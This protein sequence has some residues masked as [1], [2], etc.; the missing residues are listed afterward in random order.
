MG[1][2]VGRGGLAAS[3]LDAPSFR[4][5]DDPTPTPTMRHHAVI[6]T[7]GS[8][9]GNPGPGGWAATI[10]VL[11]D[12]GSLGEAVVL[13]GGV[14]AT[15]NNRMEVVAAIEALR[16]FPEGTA[17]VFSDSQYLIKGSPNGFGPGSPEGGRTRKGGGCGT[18]TYGRSSKLS[19][20]DGISS[21]PGSR[22][23]RVTAVTRRSTA[24]PMQRP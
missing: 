8:C 3:S 17:T 6:H 23:T 5:V 19:R 2:H 4:T 22:G 14:A 13:T 10:R 20:P 16:A 9:A 24:S 1:A 7:D 12:D 21:G 18:A 11:A 15:T